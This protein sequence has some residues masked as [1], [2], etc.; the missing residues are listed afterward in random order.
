[1]D[2]E[3][4]LVDLERSLL[5]ERSVDLEH[6]LD[7]D[8]ECLLVLDLPLLS[9]RSPEPDLSRLVLDGDLEG[10]ESILLWIS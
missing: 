1:M 3:R 10:D 2:L 4:P 8:L 7:L 9:S 5:E 6:L